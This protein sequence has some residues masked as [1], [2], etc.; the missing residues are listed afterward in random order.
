MSVKQLAQE[1]AE[2]VDKKGAAY[3]NAIDFVEKTLKELYP[4]GIPVTAYSHALLMVRVLDK[5]KRLSTD[6]NAFGESPWEDIVGYALRGS[7]KSRNKGTLYGIAPGGYKP[8]KKLE[9]IDHSPFS[10]KTPFYVH[11]DQEYDPTVYREVKSAK[12]Q[13]L[14]HL[15]KTSQDET[16]SFRERLKASEELINMAYGSVY[17]H[18]AVDYY[19][20][21]SEYIKEHEP[22]LTQQPIS[23]RFVFTKEQT[24]I[25]DE[26]VYSAIDVLVELLYDW[27]VSTELWELIRD[28]LLDLGWTINDVK[29]AEYNVYLNKHQG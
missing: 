1:I 2:T 21:H 28:T 26:D 12:E 10:P 14:E 18:S 13:Y 3:G 27:E 19:D 9:L 6:P 22:I 15:Q 17:D 16:K 7:E 4:N 8:V 5:L 24:E 29:E 25:T 11:A 20:D 23:Y